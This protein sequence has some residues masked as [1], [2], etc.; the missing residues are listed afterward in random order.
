[1]LAPR[2][3][4]TLRSVSSLTERERT[5]DYSIV[6]S[7]GGTW[8]VVLPVSISDAAAC[9]VPASVGITLYFAV[10]TWPGWSGA[11]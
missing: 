8:N 7:E 3:R 9:S 1:M 2:R 11:T 5:L 4:R 10:N 6:H